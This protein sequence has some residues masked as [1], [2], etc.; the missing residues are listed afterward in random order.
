[1]MGLTSIASGIHAGLL[2]Q[3]NVAHNLAD[4]LVEQI[5]ARHQTAASVQV[6]RAQ[7]EMIGWLL[8]MLT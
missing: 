7:D 6:F 5:R 4:E 3:A 1:M 8:D 2:R